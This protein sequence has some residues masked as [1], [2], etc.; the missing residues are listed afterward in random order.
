MVNDDDGD[1]CW[2]EE[3]EEAVVRRNVVRLLTSASSP[4]LE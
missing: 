3:K 2:N 4:T 1:S